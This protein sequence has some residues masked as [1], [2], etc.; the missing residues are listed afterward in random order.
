MPAL[1]AGVIDNL[2]YCQRLRNP[3]RG[4]TKGFEVMSKVPEDP[5]STGLG[6]NDSVEIE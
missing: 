3:E 1:I 2:E 6:K 4:P 5:A